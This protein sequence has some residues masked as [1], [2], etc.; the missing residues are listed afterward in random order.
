M[1][2]SHIK[3][4]FTII[5]QIRPYFQGGWHWREYLTLESPLITHGLQQLKLIIDPINSD[6]AWKFMIP[7]GQIAFQI[8]IQA[9]LN[10]KL[11]QKRAS[12][13]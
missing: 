13:P 5:V 1:N 10:R 7:A 3:G 6:V 8:E 4:L 2:C 9:L 11:Q 12:V